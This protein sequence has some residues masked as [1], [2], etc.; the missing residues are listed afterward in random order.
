[1]LIPVLTT[2]LVVVGFLAPSYAMSG[3]APTRTVSSIY[4]TF[5]IGWFITA[6]TATRRLSLLKEYPQRANVVAAGA[7]LLFAGSVVLMDGPTRT[8]VADLR[9]TARAWNAS[10]RDRYEI[11][12]NEQGTRRTVLLAPA[13][14]IPALFFAFDILETPT[15]SRNE[16]MAGFFNV[17]A[18]SLAPN[19]PTVRSRPTNNPPTAHP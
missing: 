2:G 10:M 9:H 7:M 3:H 4:L 15:D 18:V 5:L 13:S 8:A 16:C 1:M 17:A 19:V 14:E 12:R 6:F 11:L